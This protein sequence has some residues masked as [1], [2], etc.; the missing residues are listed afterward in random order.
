[1]E[2][3]NKDKESVEKVFNLLEE[4]LEQILD[5]K[6]QVDDIL[7]KYNK[8]CCF[9]NKLNKFL[10]TEDDFKKT[11]ETESGRE[12][13]KEVLIDTFGENL[14]E[15]DKTKKVEMSKNNMCTIDSIKTL[16]SNVLGSS[17]GVNISLPR[18]YDEL[19]ACLQNLFSVM[20]YP[21]VN[22][23][24][25]DECH[26]ALISFQNLI[27]IK[28]KKIYYINYDQCYAIKMIEK[29]LKQYKNGKIIELNEDE[30]TKLSDLLNTGIVNEEIDKN[31]NIIYEGFNFGDIIIGAININNNLIEIDLKNKKFEKK[32]N[33]YL[34]KLT[35]TP[36]EKLKNKD[37]PKYNDEDVVELYRGLCRKIEDVCSP[38]NDLY[39]TL[40]ITQMQYAGY[41]KSEY[42]DE[43]KV[44][45]KNKI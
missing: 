21:F 44:F 31:G 17:G 22:V 36:F 12:T 20:T 19:I 32:L 23:D 43:E 13:I 27:V 28:Y 24:T 42:Y 29:I 8:F 3:I 34:K 18:S 15:T 16:L 4:Q 5:T 33:G 30:R 1:M 11:L 25:K 45:G 7:S 10:C 38:K 35:K 40:A 37:F 14:F 41:F 9:N 2:N 26:K 39:S 6:K